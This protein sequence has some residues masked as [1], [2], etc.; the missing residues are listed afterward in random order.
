MAGLHFAFFAYAHLNAPVRMAPVPI[1][2]FSRVGVRDGAVLGHAIYFMDYNTQL[3][4][5]L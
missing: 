4:K 3:L 1:F 2:I 5:P